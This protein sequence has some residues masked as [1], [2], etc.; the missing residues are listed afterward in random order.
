MDEIKMSWEKKVSMRE[1][2]QFYEDKLR[3]LD[4]KQSKMISEL[5]KQIADFEAGINDLASRTKIA[6]DFLSKFE[7]VKSMIETERKLDFEYFDKTF[8]KLSVQAAIQY[9]EESKKL[10]DALVRTTKEG[11]FEG[12]IRA[13]L[14]VD[15]LTDAFF[16]FLSKFHPN[17]FMLFVERYRKVKPESYLPVTNSY[18]GGN[19]DSTEAQISVI[20]GMIDDYKNMFSKM[21]DLAQSKRKEVLQ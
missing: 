1:I 6:T 16:T 3:D 10:S 5:N 18:V 4:A 15:V 8:K 2:A 19:V 17:Y 7:D 9:H 14:E 12:Y 11:N 20:R 21:I 13:R